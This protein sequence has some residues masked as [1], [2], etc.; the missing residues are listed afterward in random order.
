M[1]LDRYLRFLGTAR[2]GA[3]IAVGNVL[4][5]LVKRDFPDKVALVTGWYTLTLSAGAAG[6][7]GFTVPLQLAPGGSIEAALAVWT[8]PA[9][10]VGILWLPQVVAARKR[11]KVE[12]LTVKGVWQDRL[13]W[14]VTLFM[15]LQCLRMARA[16]I[17]CSRIRSVDRRR[18]RIYVVD[19]AGRRMFDRPS[20]R[21]ARKRPATDKRLFLRTRSRS[22]L[23]ADL[24][25]LV[26]GDSAGNRPRRVD[27]GG[28]YSNRIADPRSSRSSPSFCYGAVHRYTLAA[29]GPQIVGFICS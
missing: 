21:C 10:F 24:D 16:D 17:T 13:A 11:G 14:H 29:I 18:D 4:A 28:A 22:A 7:A 3:C 9:R 20:S 5:G 2:A 25:C 27:R 23:G 6:G 1:E 19:G 26:V 8:A 15:G 12:K